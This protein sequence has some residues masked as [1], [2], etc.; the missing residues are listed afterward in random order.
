MKRH[1]KSKSQISGAE[2][3]YTA[4]GLELSHEDNVIDTLSRVSCLN[5]MR[6]DEYKERDPMN[7]TEENEDEHHIGPHMN[8]PVEAE[9]TEK[10]VGGKWYKKYEI[11]PIEFVMQNED[12]LHPT[13]A[14]L[15][16]NVLKYICRHREKG[17]EDDLEKAIHY[18][19]LVKEH[20]Y[21]D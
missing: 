13:D 7:C 5:C 14:F 8:P 6:S 12:A 16:K 15:L 18:I 10:Q 21:N 19:E 9:A 17:G 11:Q 20:E 3:V 4:C 2:Y 1:L